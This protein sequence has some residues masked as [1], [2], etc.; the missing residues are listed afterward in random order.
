MILL[1]LLPAKLSDDILF[2]FLSWSS[3]LQFRLIT[4]AQHLTLWQMLQDIF[5][6]IH[7]TLPMYLLRY[8]V[9]IFFTVSSVYRNGRF[10]QWRYKN[11]QISKKGANRPDS[12]I[13]IFMQIKLLL[14]VFSRGLVLKKRHQVAQKLGPIENLSHTCLTV[15]LMV[16]IRQFKSLFAGK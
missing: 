12:L 8:N 4:S 3:L 10:S 5:R 7:K 13:C 16:Q 1:K 2:N 15:C 6:Y 11:C 14:K 9:S